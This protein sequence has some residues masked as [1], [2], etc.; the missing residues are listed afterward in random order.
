MLHFQNLNTTT[1]LQVQPSLSYQ[2][3]FYDDSYTAG[4][5]MSWFSKGKKEEVIF[6]VHTQKTAVSPTHSWPHKH[7]YLQYGQFQ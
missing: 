2:V 6:V 3:A 5:M 4:R 1:T 7:S